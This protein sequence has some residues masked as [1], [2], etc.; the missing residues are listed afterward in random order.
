VGF[1]LGI[2]G[3]FVILGPLVILF[4]FE[5][6]TYNSGMIEQVDLGSF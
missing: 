4:I 3:S 6:I 1:F 5:F 2:L